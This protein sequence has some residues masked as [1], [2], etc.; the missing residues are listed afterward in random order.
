MSFKLKPP[1]YSGASMLP[2]SFSRLNDYE[3]CP[4]YAYTAHVLKDRG[5]QTPY[6]ARG[7]Q[8]HAA[9]AAYATRESSKLHVELRNYRGELA[10]LRKI[11]GVTAE[12]KEGIT[13]KWEATEF[14]RGVN[15][16]GRLV[17]DLKWREQDTVFVVD[18]KTGKKYSEHEDQLRMY[19]AKELAQQPDAKRA[20][21]ADWY[22]DHPQLEQQREFTQRD[23]KLLR[24][25]FEARVA[26]MAKDTKLKPRPNAKCRWCHLNKANG[27]KC[28]AGKIG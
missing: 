10:R 7:E 1:T 12:L 19:A 9:A 24:K 15:L 18:V 28:D 22:V 14:F 26:T 11:D 8:L 13:A 4:F 2:W 27:G 21:V 5:P 6:A 17:I 23:G 16:W 20:I 3:R 25:D